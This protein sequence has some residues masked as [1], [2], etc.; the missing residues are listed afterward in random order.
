MQAV[1]PQRDQRIDR[2]VE[3]I[4]CLA[5]A[6]SEVASTILSEYGNAHGSG[7][8]KGGQIALPA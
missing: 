3:D 4:G 1:S 8:Q 2:D 5:Q 6:G 7:K